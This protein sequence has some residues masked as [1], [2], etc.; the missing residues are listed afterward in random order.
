MGWR[1]ALW[2]VVV[3]IVVW[4]LYLVRA[5]LAPF[6]LSVILSVLLDPTIRRLRLR[7]WPRWAAVSSVFLGFFAV[8]SIVIVLLAPVVS[9]QVSLMRGRLDSIS[10]QLSGA[11]EFETLIA[12]RQAALKEA[13]LPTTAK[14]WRALLKEIS[15]NENKRANGV[16]P[17][18]RTR[19]E[20][21]DQLAN[22][23]TTLNDAGLPY[24]YVEWQK[25]YT[26][27]SRSGYDRTRDDAYVRVDAF[28]AANKDTLARL[29][30]PLTREAWVRQYFDPYKEQFANGLQSFLGGFLGIVSTVA[31][32]LF[33]LAFTPLITFMIL[34]DME[35]FKRRSASWIP[36]SIRAS[37]MDLLR[38]ISEVF[39]KYL[40]GMTMIVLVYSTVT[41]IVLS[42]M[43]APYA[44]IMGLLI[45]LLGLI[46]TIG[47]F[48]S[49]AVTLLVV[50]VSGKTGNFMFD[51]GSPWAFGFVVVLV[52]FLVLTTMDQIL[53]PKLVGTA[54]GLTP[55][56]SMFV[57]FSAGALFGLVGTI[58][59]FPLAGAAKVVLDRILRVATGGEAA[60]AL[61]RVPLRHRET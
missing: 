21:D 18:G 2:V 11:S 41:S 29:N 51:L 30:L 44:I 3:G 24:T 60:L 32:G 20:F 16:E 10:A 47:A 1:I 17:A 36:P 27:K 7:G 50:G 45:A 31:S 28:L 37:T 48:I 33:L 6:V 14:E 35:D 4:F 43:G 23:S 49:Y 46:P 39:V 5:I 61:P 26:E 40:R 58:I 42:I 12:G 56:V 8:V 25:L 38:D 9:G 22:W 53:Y 19:A 55:A 15:D 54:V 52:L 57:L 34:W 13:G 59:A